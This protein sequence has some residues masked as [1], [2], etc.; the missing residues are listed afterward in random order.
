MNFFKAIIMG[1]IQGITE[2]L[3]ISSSGHLL[4]SNKLLGLE[5]NISF[6]IILHAASLLAVLIYFRENIFMILG[7]I[8]K[9]DRSGYNYS[10]HLLVG[11]IPAVIA[12]LLFE[13]LLESTFSTL[14][15]VGMFL[16]LNSL[17][18][19]TGEK[20]KK[21]NRLLNLP[22]ALGIGL[23]QIF[24]LLP[25]ISRSGSTISAGLIIG[26]KR[27]DAVAFSFLMAIPLITGA[28]ILKFDDMVSGQLFTLYTMAGFISSFITSW[29]AVDIMISRLKDFRIFSLYTAVL[30]IIC[31]LC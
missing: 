25:G 12:G 16:L 22:G 3:P 5:P 17:L 2:F 9:K 23:M 21:E 4:I 29:V 1:F 26:L 13:D 6:S 28:V 31:L 15:F 10:C 30:G 18:L 27:E 7:Q 8:L 24:A 11:I 14:R 19:I 20:L